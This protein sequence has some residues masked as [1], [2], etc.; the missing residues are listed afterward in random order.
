MVSFNI[1]NVLNDKALDI[2]GNY[3]HS[4]A[5][6]N[7][8]PF[9]PERSHNR[10]G[11]EIPVVGFPPGWFHMQNVGSGDL[12]SHDYGHNSPALLAA[13]DSPV[14]SQHQRHWQFQWTL[15]HSKCYKS[16]TSGE[17]NSWYIINRQTRLP[18]SPHFGTMEEK[19]FASRDDKLAWKLELDPLCNWKITNRATSC[20]LRQMSG[21]RSVGCTD[22]VFTH[23]GGSQSWIMR[24][25]GP[26]PFLHPPSTSTNKRI[27]RRRSIHMTP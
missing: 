2:Y 25:M 26:Y 5:W 7:I 23:S 4:G 18:L 15:S 12:L 13:P 10:W 17:R 16:G 9:S 27:D 24:F 19:D 21:K 1:I 11:L 6:V 20:L 3:P 22:Q 14:E 8:Q